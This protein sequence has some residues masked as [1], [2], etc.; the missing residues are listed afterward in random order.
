[1]S[2][3]RTLLW[4]IQTRSQSC[5]CKVCFTS[6][7]C[8]STEVSILHLEH[9]FF[10]SI[11]K[12]NKQQNICIIPLKYLSF[13]IYIESNSYSVLLFCSHFQRKTLISWFCLSRNMPAI[14]ELYTAWLNAFF[15]CC[16]L[17]VKHSNLLLLYFHFRLE[18]IMYSED[19]SEGIFK[20]QRY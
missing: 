11:K 8:L 3:C 15:L 5:F 20:H 14:L 19:A 12:I 10:W 9:S 16:S 13:P 17:S 7:S 6:L 1:M 4:R 18:S 2:S